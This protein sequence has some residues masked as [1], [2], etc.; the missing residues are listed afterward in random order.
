MKQWL[1][2]G[3]YHRTLL[4]ILVISLVP[5]ALLGWLALRNA[6]QVGDMAI[7][8]SRVALDDKSANALELRAIETAQAI[9]AFM[10]ERE[11]D[12]RTVALLPPAPQ[13]YLDFFNAHQGR[14]WYLDQG[15]EVRRMVPLYRELAFIAASGQEKLK[16]VACTEPCQGAGRI[17]APEELKDVSNP[18]NTTFKSETYFLEASRLSAG[19]I[20]VG[21]VTGFYVTRAEFQAGRRFSGILR[22]AMPI[23]GADGRLEGVVALALDNR[24]LEEFTAHI[25][26]TDQRFAAASNP[27]SGNYAYIIDDQAGTIAH[28]NDF[29]KWGLG[30]EGQ[31]LPY[32]TKKE[33]I[34]VLP[35]RLDQM[36][37]ADPNLSSIHGKAATGQAGSIQ[38]FWDNH[39]KFAAYAP[40]PYYGG[41]Y[42]PP[43]GFGWVGIGA[44]VATFHE[45]ATVTGQA[46]Q[47]QIR[48]LATLTL[49]ILAVTALA[50]VLTGHTIASRLHQEWTQARQATEA[51][52]VSELK[53]RQIVSRSLVGIFRTTLQ[54]QIVE[55]NPALLKALQLDSVEH[56]NQV[57][58]LNLY[59]DPADRQRLIELLAHGPVANFET[60]FRR[61]DGQIIPAALSAFLVYDE[62]GRP[63][64]LEGTFEDITERKRVEEELREAKATAEAANQAK[65]TF[66][67]NMSHE[68]RTPLNAIIGYSEMLQEEAQDLGYDDFIPD[69]QKINAAGKHL[70]GLI[71]DILD[72][73]KIE[74]GRMQLYLE[75]FNVAEL[76]RDTV[77][78]IQPL[79]EKNA[80]VLQVNCPPDIGEMYADQTKVRQGLFNLLSNAAKFTQNGTITLSVE[81]RTAGEE[82]GALYPMLYFTVSDTGIGMTAEQINKLFQPFMQAD[83]STTRKYGGTGLGLTIT[84]HFCQMMGGDITVTS[85]AGR[86]STF[87]IRLPAVAERKE[88]SVERQAA[89]AERKEAPPPQEVT[90]PTVLVIDDDPVVRDLLQRSLSKEGFRVE[91]A[92]N[93]EEGL[94]L[95]RQLNPQ[96]ITLDVMMPDMNGWTVLTAIK[97]DP[98]L[99]EVP[100]I[101][102]TIVEEKNLGFAL[103]ASDYL[104]KP[105]EH[106]RLV[107]TLRKYLPEDKPRSLL[108]VEDDSNTRELMRR[109]L[110]KE[111]WNI[112]EAENGR[113][114]LQRVAEHIPTLILLDLMM[115]EMDGFEFLSELRKR[116]AWRGIPVIVVTAKDLTDEDRLRLNGYVEKILQ[117]GA[118][119]REALLS[120]VHDLVTGY[121]K[122]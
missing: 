38:Y 28:P 74:A 61:S 32:A 110:E 77:A 46:I 31:P 88:V 34:G 29:L 104:T 52:R 83:A 21:H 23:F 103:G 49:V 69:L 6:S 59:A 36:G 53:F 24:H 63:Q 94:R 80:N 3:L 60:R 101:M 42:A 14:L 118:Y 54:G 122:K 35:P 66:L 70:L 65:S 56:M 67:A 25:V 76:V 87:T 64:F 18:A 47:T 116:E 105:I 72:L 11:A 71:N 57:G 51:L 91:C 58:L 1:R 27:A 48:T 40:I 100:V 4:S 81:R 108:I 113:I 93:G 84:R 112:A 82:S 26:P 45:A 68:L 50:V 22:L 39:D 117:K 85:E 97:T 111:G 86:G 114:G 96:V 19:E 79:I 98:H 16:I 5:L 43:A 33:D 106:H 92:A 102:L 115:P 73:S 109:T 2:S 90:Q 17:A 89:S 20:Y 30:P 8:R 15:Q 9:A 13:T 44:D 120:E 12:L 119:S 75:T 121:L 107:G 10:Q 41:A 99:A 95:A 78:T 7:Q 37:F 55:A 62:E